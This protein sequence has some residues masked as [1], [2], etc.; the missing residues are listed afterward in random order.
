MFENIQVLKTKGGQAALSLRHD[1]DNREV[2][3]IDALITEE[4]LVI[5]HIPLESREAEELAQLLLDWVNNLRLVT[6]KQ[7][8]ID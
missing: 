5:T 6:I 2:V 3:W 4:P 1:K 7:M 8:E